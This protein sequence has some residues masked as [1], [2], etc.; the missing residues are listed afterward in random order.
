MAVYIAEYSH[1][2][3]N[4][5]LLAKF[6]QHY[7]AEQDS[8]C[9]AYPNIHGA[10]ELGSIALAE[11]RAEGGWRWCLLDVYSVPFWIKISV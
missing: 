3:H 11:L 4:M 6:C 1:N 2:I 8:V 5:T 7:L 9:C 10:M